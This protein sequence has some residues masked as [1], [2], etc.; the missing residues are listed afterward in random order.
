MAVKTRQIFSR[1]RDLT[2]HPRTRK[3]AI[4]AV[5]LVVAFGVLL[6]LVAPPLLRGK[7]AR[8]LSQKLHREVTIEQ[9]RLNPYAM[10]A[11]VRGFLM[12][13]R[14]SQGTAVSF[15]ELHVN[16]ELQSIFRLSPVIKEL[17]LLKP[18]V[19]LVRNEDFKY[20]FQDIIDDLTSGPSDGPT[21]KFAL[22]NIQLIDGRI[23]F[24]DR[25]EQTKHLISSINIGV[26]FISSLPSYTDIFV[27]PSFSAIINGSPLHVG[28]ASKPFHSTHESTIDL[29]IDKLQIKKYLEYS[30][31]ALNFKVPSGELNGKLNASFKTAKDSPSIFTIT[32][33]LALTELAVE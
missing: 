1:A 6:G 4:W 24:D 12:K 15:D 21:P 25:P 30:P 27:K 18:Y 8:D 19:N 28:G 7:I 11:T 26:P 22:N 9:I 5:S 20:N 10:T 23:E 29:N 31:V 13:E 32:G 16:L 3:I 2:V 17:R 33:N 14:E